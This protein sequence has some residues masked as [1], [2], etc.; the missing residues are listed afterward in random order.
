MPEAAKSLQMLIDLIYKYKL[1]PH[2]VCQFKENPSYDYY[3]ENKGIFLRSWSAFPTTYSSK[4]K[5]LNAQLTI[6]PTPH[7][8][9]GKPISVFG[10]WNLMISKY[11]SKAS[12]SML[13]IN[14]VNSPEAQ[15]ILY[16]ES[17]LLPINNELY[18]DSGY[19]RTHKDLEFYYALMQKGFHR[20]YLENY[21][22]ISDILS[23]YLNL[24]LLQ[25]I[26]VK[27]ALLKAEEKIHSSNIF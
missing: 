14:F 8:A 19:V 17:G 1:S 20:P 21:T 12:E 3:V 13:F 5:T 23:Y 24:A 22:S 9:D 18:S 25:K 15:R 11:S 4:I 2:Q 6:V 7:F 10:G 27:D 16:E 26:T